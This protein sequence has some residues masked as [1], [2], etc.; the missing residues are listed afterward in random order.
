LRTLARV[1]L[2]G[3]LTRL[4]GDG[5]S[6]KPPPDTCQSKPGGNCTDTIHCCSGD[7][8]DTGHCPCSGGKTLCHGKC[9]KTSKFETD[10]HK[11]WGVWERLRSRHDVPGR[12]LRAGRL[13]ERKRLQWDATCVSYDNTYTTEG[14]CCM[15]GNAFCC[16]DSKPGA[17]DGLAGCC[18]AGADCRCPEEAAGGAFAGSSL[19]CCDPA[20]A[21]NPDCQADGKPLVGDRCCRWPKGGDA[22]VVVD[23]IPTG[24]PCDDTW[25]CQHGVCRDGLGSCGLAGDTCGDGVHVCCRGDCVDGTCR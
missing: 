21:D 1:A 15:H 25:P 13:S 11:L 5:A 14:T 8:D 9:V 10:P 7:C 18:P 2:A 12:N 23:Y 20:N 24:K 6:A 16:T 19:D 4:G 17:N 22:T 3:A